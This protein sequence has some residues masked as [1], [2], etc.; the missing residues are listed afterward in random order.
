MATIDM[1]PKEGGGL[2]CP[3]RGRSYPRLTQCGLGRGLLPYLVASFI[4]PFGHN[5]HGPKLG[6]A[7]PIFLGSWISIEQKVARGDAYF[8]TKWHLSSFSRLATTEIAE[9][10]ELCLFRC[11]RA[12]SPSN[13]M[14][15]M[16]RSTPVPSGILRYA[17]VWPQ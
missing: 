10:W 2:L 8:N 6:G 17:A 11:G 7:V 4:Q 3:F 14:S 9:N 13:T 12:E 1:G 15:P 16:L 5:K